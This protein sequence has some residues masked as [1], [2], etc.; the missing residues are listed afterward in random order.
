[1]LKR[2]QG[3]IIGFVVCALLFGGI[4][5]AATG[6]IKSAYFNDKIKVTYNGVQINTQ[7]VTAV[8]EGQT[9]GRNF[10]SYA[11]TAKALGKEVKWIQANNEIAITDKVAEAASV[12]QVPKVS[13]SMPVEGKYTPD[14]IKSMQWN[15]EYYI[16]VGAINTMQQRLHKETSSSVKYSLDPV[17]IPY[18]NDYK[19]AQLNKHIYEPYEP[20]GSKLIETSEELVLDN[21]ELF[22]IPDRLHVFIKY[23]YYIDV[24]KPLMK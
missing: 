4:A 19:V 20:L 10:G 8:E 12:E 2:L 15:G 24:I 5:Y 9:D 23:D 22:A 18:E 17:T 16:D 3:F 13:E 11:D 21:I 1:M 7:T 14:G 6:T